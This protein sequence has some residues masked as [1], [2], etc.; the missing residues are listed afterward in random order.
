MR[1]ARRYLMCLWPGLASL[2]LQGRGMGLVMA[3]AFGGFLNFALIVTWVWP[4]MLGGGGPTWLLPTVA[5]LSVLWFWIAGARGS[6]RLLRQERP[7]NSAQAAEAEKLFRDA[8][9]E[10]LKG[11]WLET[12]AL[13]GRLLALR[14][15]DVE[16]TL[17]SASVYRRTARLAAARRLLLGLTE[18]DA[19]GR[20]HYE[21]ANELQ[22]IEQLENMP[23]ADQPARAA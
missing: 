8:Q 10:Y 1:A 17:L 21:L 19:A 9:H 4:E 16:A 6:W 14:P 13:L 7:A 11:H 3:V 12:E 23:A 18:L 5:W 2:W 22:Q 15:G 20:W